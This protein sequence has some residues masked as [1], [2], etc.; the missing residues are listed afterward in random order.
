MLWV[1][2]D[3]RAN[4]SGDFLRVRFEMMRFNP[5][6]IFVAVVMFSGVLNFYTNQV[7]AGSEI[8][9]PGSYGMP[10]APGPGY[11]GLHVEDNYNELLRPS[12]LRRYTVPEEGTPVCS[13]LTDPL[14]V[15]K[16]MLVHAILPR[17]DGDVQTDCVQA[18]SARDESGVERS[19]EFSQ[20]FPST[21]PSNFLGDSLARIPSGSSPSIWKIPGVSHA[22]GTDYMAM[23]S[24]HGGLDESHKAFSPHSPSLQAALYPVV[25]TPGRFEPWTPMSNG[26]SSAPQD[27]NGNCAALASGFC[28]VRQDFPEKQSFSITLKL[29]SVPAGWLR[30]RLISPLVSYETNASGISLKVEAKPALVPAVQVWAEATKIPQSIAKSSACSYDEMCGYLNVWMNDT[31]VDDWRPFYKDKATWVRGQWNFNNGGSGID[32]GSCLSDEGIFHGLVA[33]NASYVNNLLLYS[34]TDKTF[35]SSV[36]SPH[37][38]EDGRVLQGFYSLLVRS[39]TAKCLYGISQGIMSASVSVTEG[40]DGAESTSVVNVVD[41]GTW[42]RVNASGFHYSKPN[43]K[44][45]LTSS[46]SSSS[47]TVATPTVVMPQVSRT[48]SATAKSIATFAKLKVLSTSK[49]SLRVVASSAKYCKVYGSVVKGLKAGSCRITVSVTPQKGKATS[50]TVT[51]KVTK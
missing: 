11:V 48:K 13:G 2:T 7:V 33:T 45:R 20:Y 19:G 22:G 24:I 3:F 39:S 12:T 1:I 41:D 46:M 8:R 49:V 21:A 18:I 9:L 4:N 35:T 36:G 31:A 25:V 14:C 42:L 15:G 6:R 32:L 28:A 44:V 51:L 5:V 16:K 40:P 10:R 17:C 26:F 38:D 23:V 50:K 29:S 37:Y 30:G 47:A 34:V 43:I 27:E